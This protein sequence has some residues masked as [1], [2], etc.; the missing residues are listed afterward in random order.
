MDMDKRSGE[1]ALTSDN[2]DGQIEA[3]KQANKV[4]QEL[5]QENIDYGIIPGTQSKTMFKSG[6]QKMCRFFQIHIE[7]DI[8]SEILENGHRDYI[9]DAIAK[10]NGTDIVIGEGTG[11]CTTMESKYRYRKKGLECPVCNKEAIIKGRAEYGG[12]WVCFQKKGG[13]GNKFKDGDKTIEDQSQGYIEYENPADYYNTC[14]KMAKKRAFV[15]ATI[16]VLGLDMSQDLDTVLENMFT[17]SEA[18][19]GKGT[20]DYLDI[21]NALAEANIPNSVFSQWLKKVYGKDVES[22][23]VLI[24][25]K[26]K[27]LET[28]KNSPHEIAI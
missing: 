12:G 28:I 3:F 7:Y 21:K 6:A 11:S 4:V 17:Y 23:V 1:I 18:N 14:R 19:T 25:D 26:E 9:V 5:L 8:T 13:C 16:T 2:W 15:D 24:S 20:Q 27:I 10:T 22:S